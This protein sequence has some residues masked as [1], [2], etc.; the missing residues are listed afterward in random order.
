MA[1]FVVAITGGIASGKNEVSHR[2]QQLGIVIADADQAARTCAADK[3]V[4]AEI[5]MRFGKHFLQHDGS[6][7]RSL[8]RQH[9]FSDPKA[10]RDLETIIHPRIRQLLRAQCTAANSAYVIVA[11]PLLTEAG[12]FIAYPWLQRILVVDAPLSVQRDRLIARDGINIALADEMIAS[13]ASRDQRLA[14]ATDVIINDAASDALDAPVRRLDR[15][16][17]ELVISFPN[18]L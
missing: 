4:L 17:R 6:L 7:N 3:T 2:F 9:I 11:I 14:L 8:L 1:K 12:G 5:V 16:Y 13:Q 18:L 10:R 15:L